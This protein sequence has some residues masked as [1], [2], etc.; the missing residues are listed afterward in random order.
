M[1]T[2]LYII[3]ATLLVSV[4]SFVG[5]F[6]LSLK[7]EFL[8]RILLVLVA[9]AAGA[10]LGVAAFDLVPEALELGGGAGSLYI[11]IGIL[12]FFGVERFIG[13]HHSHHE[14]DVDP[15]GHKEHHHDHRK[16][17]VYVALASEAV[18]NFIDGMLIAASFLVNIP[19]GIATT[20]AVCMHEIPQEIGDFAILLHGGFSVKKALLSNFLV[21]ITAVVGGILAFF[22]SSILENIG[23][24]LI[25]I[26]GGGFLYLA[27]ADLIPEINKGKGLKSSIVQIVFLVIGIAIMYS[28]GIVLPHG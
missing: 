9:F 26:A 18:H 5:V 4:I 12:V 25:G 27:L 23:P 22:L 28:L 1:S 10:L 7:R 24:A 6:T 13:W 14:E 11:V 20:I 16:P 8:K 2:L 3:A 21:A 15:Q 19:L 17:F